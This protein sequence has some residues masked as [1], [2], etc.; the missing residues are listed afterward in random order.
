M[1]PFPRRIL[2]KPPTC[3]SIPASQPRSTTTTMGSASAFASAK[4]R[5][6]GIGTGTGS[7]NGGS[8]AEWNT[9]NEEHN[10]QIKG[11]TNH[12]HDLYGFLRVWPKVGNVGIRDAYHQLVIEAGA[13]G[14]DEVVSPLTKPHPPLS[15]FSP[16]SLVGSREDTPLKEVTSRSGH[17]Q[18]PLDHTNHLHFEK[19]HAEMNSRD[20]PANASSSSSLCRSP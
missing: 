15:P 10:K 16:L 9:R 11:S 6:I 1:L 8:L 7:T 3:G 18:R 20:L 2:Q 13:H 5:T 17:Q 14:P 4:G 12:V 19:K